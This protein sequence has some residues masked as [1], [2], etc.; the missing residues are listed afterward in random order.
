MQL[1]HWEVLNNVTFLSMRCTKVIYKQKYKYHCRIDQG[2]IDPR[3]MLDMRF[4]YVFI[5]RVTD[6]LETKLIKCNL[7][8]IGKVPMF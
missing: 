4:V 7:Q 5:I 1:E 8:D 6:T 3:I 2:E